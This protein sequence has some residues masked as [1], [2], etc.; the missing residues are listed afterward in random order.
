MDSL[1]SSGSSHKTPAAVAGKS[2]ACAGG[3]LTAGDKPAAAKK[4]GS[5]GKNPE[6]RAAKA[7]GSAGKG[8]PSMMSF[9][10]AKKPTKAASA[11]ASA[12]EVTTPTVDS[13]NE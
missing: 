12:P 3:V 1:Q 6:G 7:A 8:M 2:A 10:S 11:L 13:L 5:G 4:H 9:F